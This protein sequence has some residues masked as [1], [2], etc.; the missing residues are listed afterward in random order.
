M[1]MLQEALT[2]I[3]TAGVDKAR[4]TPVPNSKRSKVEVNENGNWVFV[5]ELDTI[6]AEDILKQATNRVICG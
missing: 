6:I 1:S 2:K 4:I 3:R 5:L